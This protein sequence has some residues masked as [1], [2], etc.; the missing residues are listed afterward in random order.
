MEAPLLELLR[1][2]ERLGEANGE[3]YD[4]EAREQIGGIIMDGFLRRDTSFVR[5]KKGVRLECHSV[6][7]NVL[8]G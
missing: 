4:S 6:K 5:S 1:R 2:L 7:R 3:L 8:S